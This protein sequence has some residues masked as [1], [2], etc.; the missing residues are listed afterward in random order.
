[1][2]QCVFYSK[3]LL[4][5]ITGT[6]RRFLERYGNDVDVIVF[7]CDAETYVS[8]S[9]SFTNEEIFSALFYVPVLYSY[10]ENHRIFLPS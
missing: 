5:F 3:W 8:F 1:M 10:S 4:V 2:A 9:F 7:V 6:V